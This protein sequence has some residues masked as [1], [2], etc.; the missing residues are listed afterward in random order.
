MQ[1][2]TSGEFFGEISALGRTPRA[3]TVIADSNVEILELRWQG[4]R[5]IRRYDNSIK[6][7][8]DS[9]YRE[10]SLNI[11]LQTTQKACAFSVVQ[12]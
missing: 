9:L 1:Y 8:I 3:T 7:H 12:C 10:R 4:L 11:H 2:L 6:E 5:D